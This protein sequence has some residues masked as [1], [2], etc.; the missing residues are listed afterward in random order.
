MGF[1]R[2][3]VGMGAAPMV[4]SPQPGPMSGPPYAGARGAGF[5]GA[6]LDVDGP[7]QMPWASPPPITAYADL[8]AASAGLLPRGG[9]AAAAVPPMPK[10]RKKRRP[11]GS[12]A[13][14]AS[15]L[16][17]QSPLISPRDDSGAVPVGPPWKTQSE[18]RDWLLQEKRKWL[19][20]M[21]LQ[22]QK[23]PG[24]GGGGGYSG[25]EGSPDG[26]FPPIAHPRALIGGHQ[27][28]TI[29]TP[30]NRP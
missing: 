28:D 10:A 3:A 15:S 13:A 20:E 29:A 4:T 8:H 9:A 7:L 2:S 25:D 18:R 27:I 23:P 6:S 1:A 5:A 16:G 11:G 22:G 21:R 24:G 17:A 30:R 19:V 26:R 14:T 12:H